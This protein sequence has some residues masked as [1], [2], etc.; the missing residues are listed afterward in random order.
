M[1]PDK[2]RYEC[3]AGCGPNHPH[4]L[5]PDKGVGWFACQKCETPH[6][7]PLV[8]RRELR[9]EAEARGLTPAEMEEEMLQQSEDHVVEL[10]AVAAEAEED[11]EREPVPDRP[12]TSCQGCPAA[13][14]TELEEDDE[15]LPIPAS[16]VPH[17]RKDTSGSPPH[18]HTEGEPHPQEP[19]PKEEGPL[20]AQEILDLFKLVDK[21]SRVVKDRLS[22]KHLEGRHGWRDMVMGE[23]EPDEASPLGVALS[24][25]VTKLSIMP[26]IDHHSGAQEVIDQLTDVVAW[27]ALYW[28]WL[29]LRQEEGTSEQEL[30]GKL[31]EAGSAMNRVRIHNEEGMP[32]SHEMIQKDLKKAI[33][34]LLEIHQEGDL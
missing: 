30:V 1:S 27:A 29:V 15:E 10:E 34:R 12:P 9:L 5:L 28:K 3:S 20:I 14:T 16:T 13:A 2:I 6:Y 26:L 4:Y 7:D 18:C 22:Q 17:R 21:F 25:A 8:A 32:F 19:K 11:A 24:D 31:H 23:P 33:G